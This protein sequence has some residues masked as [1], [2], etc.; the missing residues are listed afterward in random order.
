MIRAYMNWSGGKDSSLCLRRI[1]ED[2]N[3][4]V[5]FLLTSVNSFHNRISM[6]GVRRELLMAQAA[7]IGIP[8]QTL[9]LPEQPGMKEYEQAMTEKII[10]LK[11]AGCTHAIFGDIFLEDLRRY[12]EEKLQS[13]EIHCEFPLWK[14][15]TPQLMK[16]FIALGFRAVIVCVNEKYLDKSFCGRLIDESFLQDLPENADP[17]GEN[18]E[19]HSFVFEGPL[20]RTPIPFE[21]GEITLRHYHAPVNSPGPDNPMDQS[22]QASF[23]FCDLLPPA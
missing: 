11:A 14:A 18:G 4:Q 17:C 22:S 10:S 15:P 13:L 8:L 6:H 23:Y 16:E 5:D 1:M 21:K 2:R 9:E 7:S 12:R 19:Y 3:Y 20:F